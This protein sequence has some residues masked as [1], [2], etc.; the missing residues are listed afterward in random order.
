M[1]F[2]DQIQ[3]GRKPAPRRIMLYGVQGIGKSTFAL[4][5]ISA[6]LTVDPTIS[7]T[8]TAPVLRSMCSPELAR[9]PAISIPQL[10]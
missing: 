2:F 7:P 8:R 9:G 10:R 5:R 3:K 4:S 1:S 6:M